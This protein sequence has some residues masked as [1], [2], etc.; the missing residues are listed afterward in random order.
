MKVA[1]VHDDLMRR[2]GAEKV[3]KT[4]SEMFP[5]APIYTLAYQPELTYPEFKNKKVVTSRFQ[6][7]ARNEFLMKWLFFPFGLLAM[8]SMKLTGYDLVIMSTTYCAK[9]VNVEKGTKVVAYCYTPSRLAWNPGSYNVY[10][11]SV[12]I[13]RRIFNTVI[14]ILQ[15]IDRKSSQKIHSFVAMTQETKER[16]ILAYN[17]INEI[18]IINPAVELNNYSISDSEKVAIELSQDLNLIRKLIWL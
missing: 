17:P 9:Y 7:L 3:A 8:K 10:L 12:G 6:I 13:T 16:L 14:K 4:I 1:I 5:E 11:K 2:G 18:T 15:N